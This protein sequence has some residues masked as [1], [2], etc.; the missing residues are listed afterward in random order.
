M[1]TFLKIEGSNISDR[2]RK[3]SWLCSGQAHHTDTV[4]P[5]IF[6][7]SKHCDHSCLGKS[8]DKGRL[9]ASSCLGISLDLPFSCKDSEWISTSLFRSCCVAEVQMSVCNSGSSRKYF[10]LLFH[11]PLLLSKYVWSFI[12]WGN[13][14]N[15][16]AHRDCHLCEW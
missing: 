15:F 6:P 5:Q 13:P 3:N 1:K 10:L 16:R 11:L 8:H 12:A 14:N 4:H 7:L 9:H 2:K